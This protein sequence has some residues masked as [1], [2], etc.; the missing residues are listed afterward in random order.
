[1]K[2]EILYHD[3]ANLYGEK[4]HIDFLKNVFKK[5]DFIYTSLVDKPKFLTEEVKLV[6]LGPMSEKNQEKAIEKLMVYREK[7]LNQLNSGQHFLCTGNALEIFG[8]KIV[9]EDETEI[10]ALNIFPYYSKRQM[11]NRLNCIYLGM[12]EDIKVLG[13]KTQFTQCYPTGELQE[14]LGT[15]RGFGL[16]KQTSKEGIVYNNFIGTYLIGPLLILN[17]L[18]TDR[19]LSK[20]GVEYKINNFDVLKEAYEIRLKEFED[21]NTTL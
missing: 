15:K 5:A 2:I 16:N 20:F 10:Q 9:N 3:I 18:F 12:Y 4:G 17:P 1:M 21:K 6:L 14:F 8:E 7:I 11:M 19:W 13:F